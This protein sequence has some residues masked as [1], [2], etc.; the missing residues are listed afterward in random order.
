MKI[1]LFAHDLKT[2]IKEFYEID[3]A[4]AVNLIA[5][6]HVLAQFNCS[7]QEQARLLQLSGNKKN[8]RQVLS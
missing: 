8:K 5:Q 1:D 7:F 3:D 4:N 2:I 6:S